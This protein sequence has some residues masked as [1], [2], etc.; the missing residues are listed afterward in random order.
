MTF[1]LDED[2]TVE[3]ADVLQT[4][5]HQAVTTSMAGNRGSKD[6]DQLDYATQINAVLI[7][8]NRR[9]F[10]RLHR[11]WTRSDRRHAGLILTRQ[12]PLGELE[13]RMKAFLTFAFGLDVEG[14]LFDLR[15]FA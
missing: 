1:Y 14:M 4:Q 5:G 7:T 2:I 3:L 13:R 6:E 12:L 8:H 15:D 9:H 11:N 10:R